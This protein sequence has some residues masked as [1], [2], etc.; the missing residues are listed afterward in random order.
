MINADK[1]FTVAL[2]GNDSL[3][4]PAMTE[5]FAKKFIEI[6]GKYY[7]PTALAQKKLDAFMKRYDEFLR[8]FDVYCAVDLTK[9]EFAY[10][11]YYD[12]D[13]AQ[14]TVFIADERWEDLRVTIAAYKQID[15]V[16]IIFMSF[17]SDDLFDLENEGWQFE[18]MLGEIWDEVLHICNSALT[19]EQLGTEDVILDIISQGTALMIELLQKEK[20]QREL[21]EAA[22]AADTTGIEEVTYYEQYNDPRFVPPGWRMSWWN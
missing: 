10:A 13:D 18:L 5:L 16:E 8:V 3:L 9:G 1:K 6:K 14:W 20:E 22:E 4:E 15:P 7:V 21:E 11:K 17:I 2:D 12:M 19:T